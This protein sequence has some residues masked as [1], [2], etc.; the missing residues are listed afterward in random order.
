M[1]RSIFLWWII[2]TGLLPGQE[3]IRVNVRLV[4][5]AFSVRDEHGALVNNVSKEDV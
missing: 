2:V 4:N 1:R 3:P 5:V